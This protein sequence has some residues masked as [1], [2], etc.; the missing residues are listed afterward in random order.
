MIAAFK[1]VGLIVI[2]ER[3]RGFFQ[4]QLHT[5]EY[6]IHYHGKSKEP[7]NAYKMEVYNCSFNVVNGFLKEKCFIN[8]RWYFKC[9]RSYRFYTH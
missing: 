3:S 1:V 9:S 2:I 5:T 6:M 8:D 4:K 7:T